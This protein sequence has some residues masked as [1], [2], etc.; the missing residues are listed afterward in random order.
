MSTAT[1]T[2]K[3]TRKPRT[4]NLESLLKRLLTD[5]PSGTM[6]RPVA[7]HKSLIGED[8]F[9]K[10]M[11]QA[12]VGDA[13]L[14]IVPVTMPGRDVPMLGVGIEI[15]GKGVM[16]LAVLLRPEDSEVVRPTD[17]TPHAPQSERKPLSTGLY[18]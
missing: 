15:K 8:E 7:I 13:T 1:T 3:R 4:N 12:L 14:Y 17:E 2:T 11:L 10:E 16:P 6:A 5:A 9:I 18:L